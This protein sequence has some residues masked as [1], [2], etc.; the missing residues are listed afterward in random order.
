MRQQDTTSRPRGSNRALLAAAASLIL[1]IPAAAFA[2]P[3]GD[4]G[5]GDHR[6]DHGGDQGGRGSR[7]DHGGDHGRSSGGHGPSTFQGGAPT[8][9][10]GHVGRGHDSGRGGA[11]SGGYQAQGGPQETWRGYDGRDVQQGEG[12]HGDRRG[13]D[14]DFRS[15]H[16]F[17]F[18]GYRQ[19]EGW[20]DHRWRHGEILPRLFW[21]RDYWIM[22]YWM[23]DLSPPPYGYVWVREGAD[24]IL[25]DE[26]TGQ[27]VEVVYGVFY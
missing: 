16:R 25:I 9:V 1:L 18:G 19:P 10:Q 17:E 24:A 4:S 13:F 27:I 5:R 2:Q 22:N 6:G 7:G 8:G 15:G 26:Y 11:P 3:Q 14:H 23:F 12:Y 20:Y 21:D